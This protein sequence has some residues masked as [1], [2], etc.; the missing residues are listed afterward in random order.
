MGAYG[1][2]NGPMLGYGE[3]RNGSLGG[4]LHPETSRPV[5]VIIKSDCEFV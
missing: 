4:D 3:D 2:S 1:D 5:F